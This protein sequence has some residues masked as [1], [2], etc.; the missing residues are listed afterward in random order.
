MYK[1]WCRPEMAVVKPP[2][3][4]IFEIFERLRVVV[5]VWEGRREGERRELGRREGRG[6]KWREGKE[7]RRR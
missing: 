1:S 3:D 2:Q 5:Q 6:R 4:C 7:W